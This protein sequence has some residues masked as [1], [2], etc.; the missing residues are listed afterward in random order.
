MSLKVS[1]PTHEMLIPAI[2]FARLGQR[3]RFGRRQPRFRL[4]DELGGEDAVQLGDEVIF[5]HP[6]STARAAQ[7]FPR[8]GGAAT[9]HARAGRSSPRAVPSVRTCVQDEFEGDGAVEAQAGGEGEAALAVR[10]PVPPKTCFA[11]LIRSFH[12]SAQAAALRLLFLLCS[13]DAVDYGGKV[14][15]EKMVD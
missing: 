15:L 5:S 8:F 2:A 11:E 9:F 3:R 13:E 14:D 4:E 7:V 1:F 10:L 12:S 6:R